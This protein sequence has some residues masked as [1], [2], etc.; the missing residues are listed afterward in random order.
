MIK[1]LLVFSFLLSAAAAQAQ[2][3]K[4][5][6]IKSSAA[7]AHTPAI[8]ATTAKKPAKLISTWGIFVGDSL[9]KNEIVKLL[10]SSL[11]VRD[12]K[13]VK[14]PVISFAFTLEQHE[15]YLNDTTG[16]PSL[17]KDYTGDNFK[18]SKMTA[19]W[20]NGLKANL[21]KGDILYFDEILIQ[22]PNGKVY[23]APA[24]KFTVR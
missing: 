21:D 19:T 4:P 24:L 23:K 9:P 2:T 13:N 18:Q 16:Q 6:G 10:D 7:K 12:E 17:Y 3:S 15:P 22:H 8:T 20:V 5:G 14:Y 11:I 1:H